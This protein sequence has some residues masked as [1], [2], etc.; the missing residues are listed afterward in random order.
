[1][2]K[3]LFTLLLMISSIGIIQ[4][5]NI[6]DLTQK[7]SINIILKGESNVVGAEIEIIK[8]GK[9]VIKNNNLLFEYVD[10]LKSCNFDINTKNINNIKKCIENKKLN[11][12]IKLTNQN[13]EALFT[14][15][16]LGLYYIK[17]NNIVKNYSQMEPIL[18]MLPEEINNSFEYNIDAT[19]KID[20]QDL[21]DLTIKKIWNTDK[22]DKI[23]DKVTIE[24]YKDKEKIKT[25]ILDANNNWQE[26]IESL[27]KSDKYS[28]KEINIPKDYTVSYNQ[29]EYIFTITNTPSLVD[30]GQLTYIYEII[31]YIGFI[32]IIVGLI[33]K[34]RESNEK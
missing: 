28:V 29:N 6:V 1:M 30:T 2:K 25:I 27:P 19:P 16:D 34:K 15:L 24:L 12:F 20:I 32:L 5:Q 21:I 10:E 22:K 4:A 13:G 31:L 17:Q 26:I 7:G 33:L 14:N 11:N 3:L 23:L 18:I 9:P 8:I